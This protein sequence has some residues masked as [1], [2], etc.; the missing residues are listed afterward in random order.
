MHSVTVPG[1]LICLVQ[2]TSHRLKLD[3]E[4][5]DS[6]SDW[7]SLHCGEAQ[8]VVFHFAGLRGGDIV[9]TQ[10]DSVGE[11]LCG[12]SENQNERLVATAE[13]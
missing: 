8:E 6:S 11:T 13:V 3:A 1:S 2:P 9:E 12:N 10:A 7:C 5:S 4:A